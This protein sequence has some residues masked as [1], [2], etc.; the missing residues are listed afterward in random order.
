[1]STC[2]FSLS[3]AEPDH[4]VEGLSLTGQ[5]ARQQDRLSIRYRLHGPITTVVFPLRSDSPSRRDGLW[6][7]TCFEFFLAV[8]GMD[9]Y[10]E[11]NLSP[12][13][14]WNVYRLN[15]YREAL[16]PEAS[17]ECLPFQVQRWPADLQLDLECALPIGIAA[18]AELE[19]GICAVLAHHRDGFIPPGQLQDGLS[20]WALTHPGPEPDFHRRDGFRLILPATTPSRG[21]PTTRAEP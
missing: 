12:S 3:P 11:Y 10:W 14:H 7:S 4:A 16:K 15:G 17:Y 2:S 13:G 21:A 9:P 5:I 8:K 18:T 20:Y 6:K 1:M 19:V